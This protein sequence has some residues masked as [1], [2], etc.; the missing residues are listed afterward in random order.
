MIRYRGRWCCRVFGLKNFAELTRFD[1]HQSEIRTV[2]RPKIF[3]REIDKRS[4]K[5]SREICDPA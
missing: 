3:P 1:G 4:V 2:K 5:N